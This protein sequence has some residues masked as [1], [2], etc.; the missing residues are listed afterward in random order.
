MFLRKQAVVFCCLIGLPLFAQTRIGIFGDVHGWK[1]VAEL[2]LRQLRE[3]KV[4]HVIGMGDFYGF[5]KNPPQ[6][7]VLSSKKLETLKNMLGMIGTVTGLAKQNIFLV[8][9]NWEEGPEGPFG[10]VL[11]N[12]TLAE[13]GTLVAD[14]WTGSGFVQLKDKKILVSHV[15][16]Y[17]L[18]PQYTAYDPYTWM[19]T[20]K[21]VPIPKEVDLVVYAHTH[22]RAAFVEKGSGR[23]VINPGALDPERRSGDE[24]MSYAIYFLDENKVVFYDVQEIKEIES[25]AVPSLSCSSYLD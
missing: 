14:S 8:P 15:P 4:T 5:G 19:H 3:K 12:E 9:G 18:P 21:S 13:Y 1:E 11:T 20:Q 10:R 16:L 23:L 7:Y 22:K 17:P 25:V 2:T 24:K 6:Q